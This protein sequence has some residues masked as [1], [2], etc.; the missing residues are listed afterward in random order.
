[1]GWVVAALAGV[2][3]GPIFTAL[4]GLRSEPPGERG[5]FTAPVLVFLV[6]GLLVYLV[7]GYVAAKLA[8][9]PGGLNGALTAVF[10]GILG[11]LLAVFGAPF[12]FGVALPPLPVGSSVGGWLAAGL[13]PFLVNLFGGYVGGK[14]GEP[15]R[16]KS[17]RHG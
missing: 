15:A 5:Y 6:S 13:T 11:I 14:I 17:R 12:A 4:F 8:G 1:M 10:G 9:H 16:S 7:G 2:M 3:V